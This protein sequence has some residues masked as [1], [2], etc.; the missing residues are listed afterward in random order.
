MKLTLNL[1][2]LIVF[3]LVG[4]SIVVAAGMSHRREDRLVRPCTDSP[5]TTAYMCVQSVSGGTAHLRLRGSENWLTIPAYDGQATDKRRLQLEVEVG[6]GFYLDRSAQAI[7]SPNFKDSK[8][9]ALRYRVSGRDW[10]EAIT[11]SLPPDAVDLSPQETAHR[12]VALRIRGRKKATGHGER[13]AI[14]FPGGGDSIGA[15]AGLFLRADQHPASFSFMVGSR[16]ANPQAPPAASAGNLIGPISFP[17]LKSSSPDGQ[18]ITILVTFKD[19]PA[20]KKVVHLSP[21]STDSGEADA[22]KEVLSAATAG[23]E[24]DDTA[25]G[26]ADA[27]TKCGS[28]SEFLWALRKAL[29]EDAEGRKRAIELRKSSSA[30]FLADLAEDFGLTQDEFWQLVAPSG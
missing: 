14:A 12:N 19:R 20:E 5:K 3:T 24:W 27:I 15:D 2:V 23:K 30:I 29:A 28:P 22:V 21:A 11:C 16:A 18:D 6:D 1:P 4:A 17:P 10:A 8:F 13:P 9:K 26:F 7:I 25:N